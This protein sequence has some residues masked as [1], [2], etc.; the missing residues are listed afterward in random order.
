MSEE[1]LN[2]FE[3]FFDELGAPVKDDLC[4]MIVMLSD[5]NL[6][7]HDLAP[8]YEGAARRLFDAQT[9]VGQFANLINVVSLV[10]VYFA[11]DGRERFQQR[12]SGA[13]RSPVKIADAR[14]IPNRYASHVTAIDEARQRWK[15]LRGTK[16]APEAIADALLQ[17]PSRGRGA[18]AN[19]SNH[20]HGTTSRDSMS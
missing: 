5:E 6:A 18:A 14:K 11:I 4:F 9:R 8:D 15:T 1:L 16:F 13:R 17:P 12:E 7:V 3:R 19:A 10:D 20:E 2:D